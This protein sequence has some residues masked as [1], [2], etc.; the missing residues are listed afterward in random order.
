MRWRPY[1]GHRREISCLLLL[2]LESNG[3]KP[4]SHLSQGCSGRSKALR[5]R[6]WQLLPLSKTIVTA[7]NRSAI[8]SESLETWRKYRLNSLERY[9]PQ[10]AFQSWGLLVLRTYYPLLRLT[11]Y[12]ETWRWTGKNLAREKHFPLWE[13][14][15][16]GCV[17]THSIEP[18]LNLLHWMNHN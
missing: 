1:G 15:K 6:G 12:N 4:K 16:R 17:S 18:H 14:G 2:W 5:K 10:P 9:G 3:R 13:G 7:E 8:I 11:S